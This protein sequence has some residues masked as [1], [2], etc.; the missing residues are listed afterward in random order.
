[1][2]LEINILPVI[3]YYK[4]NQI[5]VFPRTKSYDGKHLMVRH[6]DVQEIWVWW[7]SASVFIIPTALIL[8][9]WVMMALH[10]RTPNTQ[11]ASAEKKAR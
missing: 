5:F 2:L 1:M 9:I 8:A 7:S 11:H 6:T 4:L 10:F 3:T